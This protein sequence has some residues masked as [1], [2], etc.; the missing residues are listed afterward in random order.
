MSIQDLFYLVGTIFAVVGLLLFVGLGVAAYFIYRKFK[1]VERTLASKSL[2]AQRLFKNIPS[3][4]TSK[5]FMALLPLIP[6]VLGV[7][8]KQ[9]KKG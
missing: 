6:T 3:F 9:R 1:Q 5:G 7:I 4:A 8:M 2:I